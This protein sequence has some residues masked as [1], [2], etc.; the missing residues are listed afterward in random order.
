M[1]K[2]HWGKVY[3]PS[4]SSSIGRWIK[5]RKLNL[6]KMTYKLLYQAIDLG[7]ILY[8]YRKNEENDFVW[9]IVIFILF[10]LFLFFLNYIGK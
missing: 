2:V 3:N 4:R 8:N 1:E 7:G 9:I 6:K 5:R 10:C